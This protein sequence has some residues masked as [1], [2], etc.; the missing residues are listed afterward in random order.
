M[1]KRQHILMVFMSIKFNS[2]IAL[3]FAA[4]IGIFFI[5]ADTKPAR[6]AA[7]YNPE[8][9]VSDQLFYKGD[10]LSATQIRAFLESKGSGLVHITDNGKTIERIFS[11]AAISNNINPKVLL[12]KAQ[13]ESGV[14]FDPTIEDWQRERLMGFRVSSDEY[15]GV[16]RQIHGA[17]YAFAQYKAEGWRYNYQKGKT[18]TTAD[19]VVVTPQTWATAGL[20]NY[21]PYAGAHFG[22]PESF[23][24]IKGNFFVWK[25]WIDYFGENPSDGGAIKQGVINYP[26]G[27]LLQEKGKPGVFVLRGGK[28]LGFWTRTIYDTSYSNTPIIQVDT[29]TIEQYPVAGAVKLNDGTLVRTPNG[30]V[31]VITDGK[32]KPITSAHMLWQLGYAGKPIIN[33]GSTEE[34]LHPVTAPFNPDHLVRQNGALVQVGGKPGVWVIGGGKK[35]PIWHAYIL[36]T[37]FQNVPIISISQAELDTYKMG[38]PV[39]FRD[40]TLIKADDGK[41]YLISGGKRRYIETIDTLR[42]LRLTAPTVTVPSAL[43]NAH[44]RGENLRL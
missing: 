13:Q 36:Q 8:H 26:D 35:S 19:G 1:L 27:V 44:E 30:A 39:K 11:E 43:V 41:L 15:K 40:G 29:A 18:R 32:R 23:T 16:E 22:A 24:P 28:R 42:A 34:N 9:I 17:A 14:V 6:A 3:L 37:K 21:T 38:S 4:A 33:I 2:A 5:Y 20:Y 10:G 31:F 25:R 12:I 7:T